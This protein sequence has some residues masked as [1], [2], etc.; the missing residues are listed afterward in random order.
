MSTEVMA[1][2]TQGVSYEVMGATINLNFD[3]VKKYLVR[4]NADNITDQEA[5]FFM[6]LC[7]MQKLNPLTG[8]DC[9]LIKYGKDTPAQMVVGKAAY[10]KR[11]FSHPDYLCKED[12]IVVLRGKDI[13]Q[14]EGC[15]LYPGET[16]LGGWCRIHYMRHDKECSTFKEVALTEYSSGKS[17]WAT[18]PSLMI[19]KVAICQCIRD[20]FPK[21]YEGLYTEEEMISSGVVP[22]KATFDKTEY[23]QDAKNDNVESETVVG[24]I[25]NVITQEERQ[26]FFDA[27]KQKFTN[28]EEANVVFKK[29]LNDLGVKSTEK[30]LQ[31]E[32]AKALEMVAAMPVETVETVEVEETT[33]AE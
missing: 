21:E 9:Y 4:G 26:T 14:K 20:A 3:F 12:G 8:S 5:L 13:I 22:A 6:N 2:E 18:K 24:A 16:L 32:L 31:S 29:I 10:M 28:K 17:N 33:Q 30:M 7:K 19:N 27:I 15:C 25:D 1:K 11:A 23:P